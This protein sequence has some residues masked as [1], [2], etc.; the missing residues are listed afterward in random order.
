MWADP[1]DEKVY[2]LGLAQNLVQAL[3]TGNSWLTDKNK[4][5]RLS[6][7]TKVQRLQ[8]E[9]DSYLKHWQYEAVSISVFDGTAARFHARLAQYEFHSM[10]A[11]KEKITQF[12]AGTKFL[13]ANSSADD[14]AL[15]E[16]RAFLTAHGASKN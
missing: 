12:P 15:N 10:P 5:Q 4:L 2:E 11:L 9:I 6:Q 16:L 3:A 7:L 13:L 14:Q 1:R 8:E